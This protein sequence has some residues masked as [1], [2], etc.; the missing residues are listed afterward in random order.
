[1]VYAFHMPLFFIVSGFLYK[2]PNN[3]IDYLERKAK[4]LLVPYAVFAT[5]YLLLSFTLSREAST[6]VE[7]LKSILVFPTQGMPMESALWFL[8]ALFLCC[9]IYAA[10]DRIVK[11]RIIFAAFIIA[12]TCIG[13]LYPSVVE[14][15]LPFAIGSAMASLGFYGLGQLWR[16]KQIELDKLKN[17]LSVGIIGLSSV[18]IACYLEPLNVRLGMWGGGTIRSPLYMR[19]RNSTAFGGLGKYLC[20]SV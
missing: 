9:T 5:V 3:L 6:L 7:G 11:N 15:K 10:L 2:R 4:R 17:R 14:L 8:P 18:G 20:S 13:C 12:L 16:C 19:S 1:M